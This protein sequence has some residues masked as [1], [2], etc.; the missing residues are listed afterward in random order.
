MPQPNDNSN[1][2]IPIKDKEQLF[3]NEQVHFGTLIWTICQTHNYI[4]SMRMIISEYIKEK[5]IEDLLPTP[6]TLIMPN[7]K[8]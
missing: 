2:K 7:I 1:K 8:K 5:T 4:E 3:N 6:N